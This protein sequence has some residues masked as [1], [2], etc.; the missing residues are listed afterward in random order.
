MA[1]LEE[2]LAKTPPATSKANVKGG[3]KTLLEADG[4]LDLSKNET[5]IEKAGGRKLGQ[6]ASGFAP[7]KPYSDKFKK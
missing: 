4:G 5:A 6:G 7:G 2:L 3:D 1:T